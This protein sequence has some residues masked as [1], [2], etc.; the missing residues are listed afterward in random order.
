MHK[1]CTPAKTNLVK[2]FPILFSGLLPEYLSGSAQTYS[3]Y[4]SV[5]ITSFCAPFIFIELEIAPN[6]LG[7]VFAYFDHAPPH[8]RHSSN[9]YRGRSSRPA[10]KRIQ[11]LM[12]PSYRTPNTRQ[13]LVCTKTSTM[14]LVG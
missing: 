8:K 10:P 14:T 11:S 7:E 2:L 6:V 9:L 1:L 3:A 4:A 12:I 13:D 5:P